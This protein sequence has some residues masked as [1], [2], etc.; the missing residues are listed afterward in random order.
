MDRVDMTLR[1]TKGDSDLLKRDPGLPM[2][3]ISFTNGVMR[4]LGV[5]VEQ[6]GVVESELDT[7]R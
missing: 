6:G 3:D 5:R 1:L 4:F 2:S 7:S